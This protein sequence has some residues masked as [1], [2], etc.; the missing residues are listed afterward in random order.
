MKRTVIDQWLGPWISQIVAGPDY[1]SG[2]LAIEIVYDEGSGSGTVSSHVPAI[3]LSQFIP[4]GTVSSVSFTH[5]STLKAAEDITGVDELDLA[6]SANSLR[7]AF[8]F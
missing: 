6:V 2:D 5:Y 1:Q 3:F 4:P 8:G 7:S